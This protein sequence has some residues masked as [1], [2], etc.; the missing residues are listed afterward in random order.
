MRKS[1]ILVLGILVAVPLAFSAIVTNTNQSTQYLRLLARN[2]S[3]DIDAVYYNPA[4]LTKLADGFHLALH[5]ETIGQTKTVIND[6]AFLNQST[7]EGK[8]NVPIYP[9]VYAVY[10]QGPLALSLG[11]GPN[12]GGGSAEYSKGLPS[13]ESAY[14]VYPW[15]F[16][17]IYGIPTSQYSLDM[18][19]K[20]G[21]TYL[22][23][24]ANVSYAITDVFS[25]AIGIR[26][27]TADNSYTGS[28][29]N[30]KFNFGGGSTMYPG[31]LLSPSF[32]NLSVD[33]KQSGSGFTPIL[34]LNLTPVEGLNIGVHYEFKT[35][36]ELTNATTTDDT[37]LFPDGEKSRADIPAILALGV[38]YAIVPQLRAHFSYTLTFDKDAVWGVEDATGTVA[39]ADNRALLVNSNC[40]D[41]AF[42]LE[43][44]VADFLTLS[45]GYML[46]SYDLKPEYQSDLSFALGADTFGFGAQLRVM[47]KLTIDLAALFASYKDAQQTLSYGIFSTATEK[48]QEKAWV[49][50]VGLGYHF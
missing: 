3:T 4:G 35:K 39:D 36:L 1:I 29:T 40:Y 44:D 27:V 16:T 41:L 26:Y 8:I 21:S 30:V 28:I 47:P 5:N 19:F 34:G 38:S 25:A 14:S 37:G 9:D 46:T 10:K 49:F 42:G 6:F 31:T 18:Q 17:Y 33:V 12:A 13:F 11:F 15:I 23:F 7:Y 32:R 48:Y 43:Y 45:A 50:G 24:Q 2:A 22:G 20:G